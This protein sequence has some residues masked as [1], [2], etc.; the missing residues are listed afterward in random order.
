M[1][2][3][4]SA[5]GAWTGA[6]LDSGGGC[7]PGVD[8]KLATRSCGRCL[9]RPPCR[10]HA[11]A[12]PA[13]V[14]ARAPWCERGEELVLS[15]SHAATAHC[16]QAVPSQPES[17]LC[18]G[19]RGAGG[20]PRLRGSLQHLGPRRAI[21]ASRLGRRQC[22]GLPGRTRPEGRLR[23]RIRRALALRRH[24]WIPHLRRARQNQRPAPRDRRPPR[25]GG[26]DRFCYPAFLARAPIGTTPVPSVQF[27]RSRGLAVT[28]T[29]PGGSFERF[30]VT[31]PLRGEPERPCKARELQ[32]REIEVSVADAAQ[33]D[34]QQHV[35]GAGRQRRR[36]E[37]A[38]RGAAVNRI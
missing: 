31:R 34:T 22:R 18:S 35:A 25:V 30:G 27:A 4:F 6:Q 2:P 11:G 29:A 19:A 17:A 37:R 21:Q 38:L 14:T 12:W 24:R 1:D 23:Q 28:T 8:R 3:D 32:E 7:D 13:R 10:K 16:T 15:E 33:L 26:A 9:M 20:G 36:Q 5:G